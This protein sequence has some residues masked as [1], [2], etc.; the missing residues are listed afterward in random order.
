MDTFRGSDFLVAA[1]KRPAVPL[2]VLILDKFPSFNQC[3]NT[4]SLADEIE[5]HKT[6]KTKLKYMQLD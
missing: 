4:N 2:E 3:Y 5:Y 1:P 6:V